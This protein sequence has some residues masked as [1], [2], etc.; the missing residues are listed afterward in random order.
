MVTGLTRRRLL[1]VTLAGLPL[2]RVRASAAGTLQVT[3]MLQRT[4]TLKR[5]PERIVLLDARDAISMALLDPRSM[6]RVAGWA[7]PETLDSDALLAALKAKAGRDIPVVGGLTPGSISAEA[8]IALKPDVVVTT[9]NTEGANGELS[10]Q[11]GGFGIPVLF[12]DSASSDSGRSAADDLPALM[13][14]WGRLLDQDARAE[15]FLAFTRDRFAAVAACVG[16][17]PTRKVYLEVQ[18]TYD[19]CCWAA[20]RQVWGELL[21]RAG[22]R[23]LDAATAPW[24]QKLHVEQLIAEQP[25][26]YIASGGAFARGTRPPIAPGL[27]IRE[28]QAGLQALAARPGMDLV[29][30]VKARRVSGIWTGLVVIRPLNILFVERVARWLHPDACRAIDPEATLR[31]LNARFLSIPLEMPLWASL[32]GTTP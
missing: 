14:M 20:G 23:V 10:A 29:A 8:I 5:M 26:L 16:T 12:S 18:S 11:L 24:F 4:V 28:A 3:D 19:D 17:A 2:L 6:Q 1:C 32:D 15:D 30:A 31:E 27:S 21:T 22:G 13:R 9:R 7:A 25:D